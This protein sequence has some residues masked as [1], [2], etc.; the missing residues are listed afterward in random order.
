ME[1]KVYVP[2]TVSV[3]NEYLP[4]LVERVLKAFGDAGLKEPATRGHLVRQA[5]RDGLLRQFDKLLGSDG[6]VDVYCDP[7]T[8]TPLELKNNT[9]TLGELREVLSGNRRRSDDDARIIK[10][11]SDVA[12]KR[13]A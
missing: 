2:Q 6:T 10:F 4:A 3:P 1:I 5:V 12:T 8:E 9:V 7:A 11:N 13:A